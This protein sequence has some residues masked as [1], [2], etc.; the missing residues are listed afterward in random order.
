M[1][2][3]EWIEETPTV[4][5]TSGAGLAALPGLS[6]VHFDLARVNGAPA[7]LSPAEEIQLVDGSGSVIGDPSRPDGDRDG[8]D[9]CA[10]ST[11]C[12]APSSS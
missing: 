11:S 9:A 1:A 4:V 8:F 6:T 12:A 5:G 7:A 10:W 2:T 3:A